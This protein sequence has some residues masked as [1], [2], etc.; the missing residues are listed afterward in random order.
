VRAVKIDHGVEISRERQRVAGRRR[1]SLQE[2]GWISEARSAQLGGALVPSTPTLRPVLKR[3]W[4]RGSDAL[5]WLFVSLFVGVVAFCV[6]L[7]LTQ[8]RVLGIARSA[9]EAFSALVGVVSSAIVLWMGFAGAI[10]IGTDGVIVKEYNRQRFFHYRD[11]VGGRLLLEKG[12]WRLEIDLRGGKSPTIPLGAVVGR[13]VREI[14]QRIL[15]ER[16]A[17]AASTAGD[18][19]NAAFARQGRS[20]E[21]WHADVT[22]LLGAA[23]YR[24]VRISVDDA[25][26]TLESASA[27]PG[28][29]LGA[30]MALTGVGG[31][32]DA[33]ARIR[34][35]ASV[36]L[37]AELRAAL[38]SIAEGEIDADA[39]DL[40]AKKRRPAPPLPFS[41]PARRG[42]P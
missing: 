20:V 35:V 15:E 21:A 40:A 36:T 42:R 7:G 26:E 19:V 10:E 14:M 39:I 3:R 33:A 29:R 4:R 37:D 17:F 11:I 12:K 18:D 23:D 30:A 38:E 27:P 1:R 9:A 24:R 22:R 41:R 13:D 32:I 5:L 28:R 16:E 2:D 25:I 31:R 34:S 6:A 8:M